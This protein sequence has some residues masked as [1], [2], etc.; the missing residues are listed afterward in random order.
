MQPARR[1]AAM[2]KLAPAAVALLSIAFVLA[3]CGTAGSP[4]PSSPPPPAS[5][6]PSAGPSGGGSGPGSGDPGQPTGDVPSFAPIAD[7]EPRLVVAKPGTINVH[8]VAVTNIDAALDGRHLYARLAWYSGIEP[9]NVL[10][11]VVMARDGAT[12]HL[13][14][15]E[16]TTDPNA[17]CIEIAEFKATIVDLGEVEPGTYTISAAGE[18]DP[19]TIEVK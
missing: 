11:S 13:T 15:R 8:D 14:V 12:I 17:I 9:C 19:I 6:V 2:T 5:E 10:D 7:G 4:S 3:A 18:A 1:L 16:G